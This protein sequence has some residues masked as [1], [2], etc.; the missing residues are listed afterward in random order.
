MQ[1]SHSYRSEIPSSHKWNLFFWVSLQEIEKLEAKP[2][3]LKV[4]LPLCMVETY[5][6]L[7]IV[8]RLEHK[9]RGNDNENAGS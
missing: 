3:F 8:G 7:N 4:A 5:S 9:H 2:E 6:M 1:L